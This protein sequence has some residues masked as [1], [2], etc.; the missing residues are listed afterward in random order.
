MTL[1]R[2]DLYRRRFDG[3]L[4]FGTPFDLPLERKDDPSTGRYVWRTRRDAK[5]RPSHRAND[6]RIF[7]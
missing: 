5:V 1:H 6:G 7:S 2:A 4:R 3:Y